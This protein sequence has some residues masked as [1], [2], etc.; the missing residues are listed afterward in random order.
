MNV[1][2]SDP[3]ITITTAR[4]SKEEDPQCFR[5]INKKLNTFHNYK[6]TLHDDHNVIGMNN[7]KTINLSLFNLDHLVGSY[8]YLSQENQTI[9]KE[10]RN[11]VS[12]KPTPRALTFEEKQMLLSIVNED[13]KEKWPS[14]TKRFNEAT[15][16]DF[17]TV[18]LRSCKGN[19][20][21][22]KKNSKSKKRQNDFHFSKKSLTIRFRV[23]DNSTFKIPQSNQFKLV[24]TIIREDGIDFI[25]ESNSFCIISKET[26][27]SKVSSPSLSTNS[28]NK[29]KSQKRKKKNGE[30]SDVDKS[31]S[32][33]DKSVDL[34]KSKKK[35]SIA[36]HT[37]DDNKSTNS[38]NS[39]TLSSDT[40]TTDL[41]FSSFSF[42]FQQEYISTSFIDSTILDEGLLD[43]KLLEEINQIL[44]EDDN[45]MENITSPS[46][47]V[48][49]DDSFSF[50][51]DF[52]CFSFNGDFDFDN[53]NC[54]LLSS[55]QYLQDENI[56]NFFNPNCFSYD[57]PLLL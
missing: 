20:K 23:I 57:L 13:T 2:C 40:T 15:G 26:G 49:E 3:E 48:S 34:K 42:E 50:D 14:R 51:G 25:Y 12:I 19:S 17:D 52:D 6:I 54:K 1:T 35:K 44:G 22:L 4:S 7:V 37:S 29:A 36:T 32:E 33:D 21:Q 41:T 11:E 43:D 47:T 8:T 38:S 24:I 31:Q 18:Y 16:N 46:T 45:L 56:E 9:V 53:D 5:S 39:S 30:E 27:E 10:E 28:N 55:D